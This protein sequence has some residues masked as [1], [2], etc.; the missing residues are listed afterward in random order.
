[1]W[2]PHSCIPVSQQLGPARTQ[3]GAPVLMMLE[4]KFRT[5]FLNISKLVTIEITMLGK[6]SLL[7]EKEKK[8]RERCLH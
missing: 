3:Q 7:Q 8:R 4:R 2:A 5:L 1:M 6:G